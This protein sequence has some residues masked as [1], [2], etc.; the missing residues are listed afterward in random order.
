[1]RKVCARWVPRLLTREQ[2]QTR[3]NCRQQLLK[4]CQSKNFLKTMVTVDETWVHHYDPESK[5][6]RMQW[7]TPG[8][9]TPVK[10]RAQKS[11]GKVMLTVFW[12]A[13]GVLLKDYLPRG[14][15]VN[16]Q[17]YADLLT[18][19]RKVVTRKRGI[20][21]T[22]NLPLLQDNASSHKARLVQV[23]A[24]DLNIEILPHPPYS[25]DLAP[26]DFFLFPNLKKQL[27][28][29]HFDSDEEVIL[30]CDDWFSLK[31]RVFYSQGLF[32]VKQRWQKCV[33][34][35]GGYIEKE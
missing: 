22:Q 16:G 3:V 30:A 18:K 10:P 17:Y 2:K 12:D 24:N 28:G 34:S 19:L 33:N 5:I 29:N 1:M 27:K 14:N 11:A 15:T 20:T 26:S 9:P 8:S 7:K 21:R 31:N 25:P 35:G 13:K 6:A 4:K 32:K 23:T